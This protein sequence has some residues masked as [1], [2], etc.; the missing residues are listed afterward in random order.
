MIGHVCWLLRSFVDIRPLVRSRPSARALSGGLWCTGRTQSQCVSVILVRSSM[1]GSLVEIMPYTSTCSGC[2]YHRQHVLRFAVFV[3]VYVCS[4]IGSLVLCL[5]TYVASVGAE[6]LENGW[7]L[8]YNGEPIGNGIC[9]IE[10]SC[11]R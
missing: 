5:L 6:Y 9:G 1:T 7:R 2:Y 4:F 8:G 11:D 10:W 3:G